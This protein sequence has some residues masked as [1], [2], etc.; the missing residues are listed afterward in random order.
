MNPLH[1]V[2]KIAAAVA[3]LD[4]DLLAGYPTEDQVGAVTL[5]REYLQRVRCEMGVL[6]NVAINL[7]SVPL[8][9]PRAAYFEPIYRT[10]RVHRCG[11]RR[12]YG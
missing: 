8:K 10:P 2:Q 9:K 11:I 7:K 4:A 3:K 5:L 12:V 1:E 6:A